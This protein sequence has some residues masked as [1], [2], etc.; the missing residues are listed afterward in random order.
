MPGTVAFR[1]R[2]MQSLAFGKPLECLGCKMEPLFPI[3][4]F[5]G[6]TLFTFC[7]GGHYA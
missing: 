7:C 2:H 1:G 4:D 6:A 5:V 3:E